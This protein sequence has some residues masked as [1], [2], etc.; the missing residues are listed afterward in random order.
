ME[1]EKSKVVQKHS[2]GILDIDTGK[3]TIYDTENIRVCV[4]TWKCMQFWATFLAC[5]IAIGVGLFLMCWQGTNNPYFY[6]G[7]SLL[8]L[9]IGVLLPG[10]KFK[11]VLPKKTTDDSPV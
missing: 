1:E 4:P 10:P 9:G 8:A 5:L 2:T 7:E 3:V 6:T 11:D